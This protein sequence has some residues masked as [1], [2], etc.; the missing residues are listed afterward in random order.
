V[1]NNRVIG[2]FLG[3]ILKKYVRRYA[4]LTAIVLF[5]NMLCA[6]TIN[7]LLKSSTV[8][9]CLSTMPPAV[10]FDVTSLKT[11]SEKTL[12]HYKPAHFSPFDVQ[13]YSV[14]PDI[15][16]K[17]INEY[18]RSLTFDKR[19]FPAG[20]P[21]DH[22]ATI[23]MPELEHNVPQFSLNM[24][25]DIAKNTAETHKSFNDVNEVFDFYS[26]IAKNT[27]ETHKSFNNVYEGLDFHSILKTLSFQ[28]SQ[29]LYHCQWKLTFMCRSEADMSGICHY[30]GLFEAIPID[31]FTQPDCCMPIFFISNYPIY[32]CTVFMVMDYLVRQWFRNN[33]FR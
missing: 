18:F 8:A 25:T 21:G 31:K 26:I 7:D 30:H 20:Y 17:D 23:E 14:I 10:S 29:L 22:S 13:K 2:L 1:E 9:L 24:Y 4:C 5:P 15:Q 32:V 12:S 3:L 27:A 33:H 6:M 28:M 16:I 19:L 11:I